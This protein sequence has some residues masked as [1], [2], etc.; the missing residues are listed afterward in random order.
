MS[1]G[2]IRDLT[3]RTGS[4]V[5]SRLEA[6]RRTLL[7]LLWLALASLL[8][9]AREFMAVNINFQIDYL[10]NARDRNYAHSVF[11]D[12]AAG[13]DLQDALRVKW[14]TALVFMSA[15]AGLSMGM[16]RARFGTHRHAAF[17]LICFIVLGGI[18]AA[19]HLA[20]P[21]LAPLRHVGIAILHALQ[22]PV[23]VLLIWVLS[24]IRKH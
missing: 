19:C 23:P 4:S 3:M 18:A 11:R 20:A 1:T 8:G 7:S 2:A 21:V 14:L 15:M 22:Y 5:I 12:W 16:A 9:A 13:W 17:I 24:W 6:R 10:A